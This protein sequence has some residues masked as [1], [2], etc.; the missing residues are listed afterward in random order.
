M[1]KRSVTHLFQIVFVRQLKQRGFSVGGFSV[2][3]VTLSGKCHAT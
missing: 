3:N 2:M 1:A